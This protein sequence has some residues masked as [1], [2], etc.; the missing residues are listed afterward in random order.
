MTSLINEYSI[1]LFGILVLGLIVLFA[2]G[3]GQ[4]KWMIIFVII[5]ISSLA[6]LQTLAKTSN[7]EITSVSQFNE[8][9]DSDRSILLEIYS[10]F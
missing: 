10:N 7:N 5:L 9:L 1:V 8:V 6:T 2:W 4:A 3:L